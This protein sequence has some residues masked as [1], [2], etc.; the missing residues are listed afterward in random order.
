VSERP[1]LS[2]VV[3]AYNEEAVIG[4]FIESVR[5]DVDRSGVSWEAIVVDDGSADRTAEIVREA[6]R[7]DGR[8]RLIEAPHRGKGAAVRAGFTAA[9]GQWV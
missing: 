8:L 7:G 5:A 3:P 4:R 2:I 6:A 1:Y 9:R